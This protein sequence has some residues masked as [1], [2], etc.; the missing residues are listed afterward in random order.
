M[1]SYFCAWFRCRG[2]RLQKIKLKVWVAR[3][4]SRTR[5]TGDHFYVLRPVPKPSSFQMHSVCL[6]YREEHKK[7]FARILLWMTWNDLGR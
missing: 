4:L 6:G 2:R 5:P 7:V 1:E 3:S